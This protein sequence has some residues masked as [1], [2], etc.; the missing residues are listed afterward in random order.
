MVALTASQRMKP[1]LSLIAA[2]IVGS[3]AALVAAIFPAWRIEGLV[4]DLGIDRIVPMAA[5]PLGWT[6]RAMMVVA[7]G[8]IAGW[9]TWIAANRMVGS[10]RR[11][12]RR[13]DVHPDAPLRE[14]VLAARDLGTPFLEVKAPSPAD[15][16]AEEERPLPADLDQPL[17]AYAVAETVESAAVAPPDD[18]TPPARI[19]TFELTPPN[20]PLPIRRAARIEEQA[21]AA[22]ETDATIH[23]LLDRLERGISR[24]GPLRGRAPVEGLEEALGSL[25]RLAIH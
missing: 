13:G 11:A 19:E 14:P 7:G 9:A 15:P 22:P 24:R 2:L 4:L 5:P 23:A 25:R 20:R 17:I 21:I 10:S 6:A 3:A 8:G 16:P 1:S 12:K 18:E